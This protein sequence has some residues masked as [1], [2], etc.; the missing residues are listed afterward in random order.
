M[1]EDHSEPNQASKTKVSVTAAI[2]L[3]QLTVFAVDRY[4]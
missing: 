3:K 2:G 4:R 1:P